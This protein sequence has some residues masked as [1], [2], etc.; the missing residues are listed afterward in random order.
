MTVQRWGVGSAS[1]ARV[2]ELLGPLFDP[3]RFFPDY[4]AQV[5][6]SLR[7][8]LGPDHLASDGNII[9][10]IHSWLIEIDGRRVLVDGCIGDDKDRMPFRDW[11]E[12]RT[13]WLDNLHAAGC[14]PEDVDFVLCTHLHVDH[15]GWNTRLDNGRWVP[16]FPNARYLF[17]ATELEFWQARR[18]QQHAD[19][20]DVVGDK[21]FDDSV[22]PVVEAGLVDLVDG[23]HRILD[24]L[25]IEPA[26]GHTPGSVTL[27]LDAGGGRTL[28]TGDILH[29][30][31][32]V[33]L[34][35]WNSAF[36]ELP[37]EAR[38]TRRRVLEHCAE[39]GALLM[40][41][42][43]GWPHAGTISRHDEGFTIDYVEPKA[44]S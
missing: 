27:E 24:G 37:A 41:A 32:Q 38:A 31:L 19:A 17:A 16:T 33:R 40:P 8:W 1:V 42:H 35:E 11:H 25:L 30:P 6:E 14:T 12:M 44:L 28:F 4:D 34:P 39:T 20:F 15:V 2:E 26:P 23:T 5:L 13:P 36:C 18:A 43:F 10:S 3:V 9:S 7:E 29:H 22:L 21:V